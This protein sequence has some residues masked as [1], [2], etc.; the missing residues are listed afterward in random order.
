MELDDSSDTELA[1]IAS[2]SHSSPLAPR[3]L[4]TPFS[5]SAASHKRGRIIAVPIIDSEVR[6][7]DVLDGLRIK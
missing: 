2:S 1:S 4:F 3:G 6:N 7:L 5:S